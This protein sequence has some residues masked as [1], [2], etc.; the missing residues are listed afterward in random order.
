ML[1]FCRVLFWV[2]GLLGL[3]PLFGAPPAPKLV[4][5]VPGFLFVEGEP[6]QV[7]LERS[8]PAL[9]VVYHYELEDTETTWRSQ[10]E[11]KLPKLREGE[12]QRVAIEL[13]L[14]ERGLYRLRV[15]AKGRQA[16][17]L[18]QNVA[19][20]FAPRPVTAESPWGIFY[21]PP[22]WFA[23]NDPAGAERAAASLRRLGASWIRLC[24]W[25]HAMEPVVV[26]PG[27]DGTT[28]V[29]PDLKRWKNYAGALRRE[30]L[31]IMGEIAQTPRALSSEPANEQVL[32]DGGP[33]YN[34]VKPADYGLWEQL[35]E[36]VAREFSDEI[37]LWEIWN[38]P[39]NQGVYWRGPPSGLVELV[40][41]T[42]A[43]LRRGNPDSRI[44]GCGFTSTPAG[45]FYADAALRAGL[46]KELDVFTFHYSDIHPGEVAR[47]RELLAPY[48]G[49]LPLWNTEENS[50]VP[51][52]DRAQGIERSFKFLH[53][54]IGYEKNQ[55]L[56]EKDFTVRPAG[57]AFSVGARILG[58][59][60]FVKTVAVEGGT[61]HVF[62]K[63]GSAIGYFQAEPLAR[64]LAGSAPS[65]ALT[66]TPP[67]PEAPLSV[68]NLRGKTRE[69]TVTGEGKISLV[70]S[71]PALFL[72]GWTSLETEPV[73]P[74]NLG[75][76]EA[77]AGRF[78][79]QWRRVPARDASG[80]SVLE[81]DPKGSVNSPPEVVIDF[82]VA[83][84]G[85]YDLLLAAQA[86]VVN[87]KTDTSFTW[88]LDNDAPQALPELPP[89]LP[90]GEAAKVRLLGTVH[91]TAGNHQLR[92]GTALS[93][94]RPPIALQLD[95]LALR[96]A[97]GA[98]SALPTKKG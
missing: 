39:D 98:Q 81:V 82:T 40:R 14:P 5:D 46:A 48:R 34:R 18:E 87:G 30:G 69:Q 58:N 57:L 6:V 73:S 56:V 20:A 75:R 85:D 8:G 25:A 42:A 95:A 70:T 64:F 50:M 63:N 92:L 59:A 49:D 37:D 97:V 77:E 68:T 53:V 86:V 3:L 29:T 35:M 60:T 24:F 38:E 9:E 76:F 62:A 28:V 71:E 91:L 10:G 2:A 54:A 26:A 96:R 43:G 4:S 41:R 80:Q 44:A 23:P 15:S 78:G 89:L 33:V 19:L 31:H 22:A 27:P 45:R 12:K 21:V 94:P 13:P 11:G 79:P 36:K 17:S 61:L 83:E 55:P 51:V 67:S 52:F 90:G 16:F 32:G 66:L 1:S 74:Q 47:W 93:A 72:H 88:A 7:A 84:S 65:R